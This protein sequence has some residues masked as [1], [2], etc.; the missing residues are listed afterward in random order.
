MRGADS[1]Q[2]QLFTMKTLEDSIPVAHPLRPIRA[3]VNRALAKFDGL[4]AQM[5]ASDQPSIAPE[6]LL[7]A[8]M[9]QILYSLRSEHQLMEQVQY[10]LLYRWF[11]GLT[12]D[13]MVWVPTVFTNLSIT[14]TKVSP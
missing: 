6:K 11:I 8:M 4:F 12:M 14:S 2:E 7:R 3:R 1:F 13:D 10:N 9:V 5:Y